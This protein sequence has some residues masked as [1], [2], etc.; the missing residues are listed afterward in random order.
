[1]MTAWMRVLGIILTSTKT[2]QKVSY[3]FNDEDNLNINITGTKYLSALKDNFVV[4]IDNLTYNE[5]VRLVNNNFDSIDIVC[6]YKSSGSRCIFSGGILSISNNIVD[7]TTNSIIIVCASKILASY[8]SSRLNLSLT[9]GINMYSALSIIC[10]QAG[11]NNAYISKQF[12]GKLL[13]D[14]LALS[15]T[16]A[17]I[18]ETICSNSN[19]LAVQTDKSI[20]STISVWDCSREDLRVIPLSPKSITVANGYPTLSSSGLTFYVLPTFN[21]M[22][23][24]VVQLDNSYIDI[25][26]SSKDEVL[27][28]PNKAIWFDSKGQY[29]IYEI[30]YN[31]SNR[32]SSFNL[33]LLC[34]KRDLLKGVTK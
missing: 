16:A 11:I 8:S 10:K 1:M 15:G 24:D 30:N 23:G 17:S 26:Q 18:I 21:F 25:S 31:L 14:S 7:Y 6:G 5:V 32:G 13:T 20:S 19:S 3:G 33:R 27:S 29:M 4:T 34:K 2:K 9:S 28:E 22:P 12:K